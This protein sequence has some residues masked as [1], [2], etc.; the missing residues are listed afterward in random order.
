MFFDEVLY[1][2]LG[3]QK[4]ALLNAMVYAPA[5]VL[6]LHRFPL[7]LALVEAHY[8]WRQECDLYCPQ[9]DKYKGLSSI[10]AKLEKLAAK[11][12]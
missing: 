4:E 1:Y 3:A 8:Y 2:T 7:A 11:R 6:G 10:V 9:K 5:A 12:R